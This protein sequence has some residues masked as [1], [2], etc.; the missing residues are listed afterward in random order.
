MNYNRTIVSYSSPFFSHP[1]QNILFLFLFSS[2]S[3]P[4]S[5]RKMRMRMKKMRKMRKK[6]RMAR[7]N[8][9]KI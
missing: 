4:L 7:M 1:D 5:M 2:F 9:D 3:P 8:Y 6:R